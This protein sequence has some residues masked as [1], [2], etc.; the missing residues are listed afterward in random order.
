MKH[1]TADPDLSLVPEAFRSVI[2][3]SLLKDP[4]QRI[5]SVVAMLAEA[6][7][8]SGLAKPLPAVATSKPPVIA[9]ARSGQSATVKSAM[10][11]GDEFESDGI[12]LGP[13]HETVRAE[14]VRDSPFRV[15]AK[16]PTQAEPIAQAVRDGWHST[17]NWWQHSN[18]NSSAKVLLLI[19]G[20]CLLVLNGQSLGLIVILLGA[21]YLVYYGLRSIALA[22]GTPKTAS[23]SPSHNSTSQTTAAIYNN[24]A[25]IGEN[26]GNKK[27]ANAWRA[28]TTADE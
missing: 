28:N 23:N 16:S 19:G 22:L 26:I 24:V 17:A 20:I 15:S 3:R 7:I 21:M 25:A 9:K 1:L 27:L 10:Y 4:A 12:Y 8:A 14:I 6:E 11:I 2:K 13:L 5:S 18:L